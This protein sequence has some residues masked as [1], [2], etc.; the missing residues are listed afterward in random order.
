MILFSFLCTITVASGFEKI[1]VMNR[2]VS[3]SNFSVLLD[4]LT[5]NM[6]QA[7]FKDFS[8]FLTSSIKVRTHPSIHSLVLMTTLPSPP[9]FFNLSF[10]LLV[11]SRAT[12]E[13]LVQATT[14]SRYQEC[15]QL[16]CHS[17]TTSTGG[18]SKGH[19]AG[20]IYS[21]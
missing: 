4:T 18:S 15:W 5:E 21:S 1:L 20:H 17:H 3:R 2:Q 14:P 19:S 13:E 6:T 16:V 8:N 11:N 9:S 12:E 7:E 10:S